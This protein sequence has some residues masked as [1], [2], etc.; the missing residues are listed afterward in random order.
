MPVRPASIAAVPPPPPAAPPLAGRVALVTGGA[1]RIGQAIALDLAAA[2]AHIALAYLTSRSAAEQTAAA[3]VAGGRQ[4]LLLRLDITRPAQIARA[5]K[6]IEARWGRLDLLVNNAGLYEES[7]FE[8]LSLAQWERMLATNLTGPFLVSQA[9]LPL[10]RRARPGRIVHLASLGG[11]RVFARHPHY[12]VSK[13]G[14]VHLTRVMARTLAPG[15]QVNAV[16]PGLIVTHRQP[17][18]WEAR[19]VKRTPAR[20]AGVA[21]DVAEAVRFFATC[22]PFITGQVLLVDGGLALS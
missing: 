11:M 1:R 14:L 10:L 17:R 5:L 21:G 3:I 12:S 15:V 18:G 19:L 4:V 8:D 20:R 16:A 2:G 6:K 13:A 22:S 9:A 7:N